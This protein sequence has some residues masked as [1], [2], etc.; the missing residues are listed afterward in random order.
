MEKFKPFIAG[1]LLGG[2]MGYLYGFDK[3]KK[4]IVLMDDNSTIPFGQAIRE[5]DALP[6]DSHAIHPFNTEHKEKKED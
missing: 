4:W 1:V 2:L 3:A 5:M 6:P